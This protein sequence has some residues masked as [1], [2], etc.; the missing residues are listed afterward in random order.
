M[1]EP[2]GTST[3]ARLA[4]APLPAE[5]QAPR[6]SSFNRV[7]RRLRGGNSFGSKVFQTAGTNLLLGFLGMATSVLTARLLGTAGRGELAAIQLW[8]VMIS[9]LAM[10]GMPEALVYFCARKQARAGS[11]LATGMVLGLLA[12]V[13][14]AVGAW[15]AMPLLLKAQAPHVIEASR[16]YL[17]MIP[18]S[19]LNLTTQPFLSRTNIALW[20]LIRLAPALGWL[21]VLTIGAVI[22][23]ASP[24]GLAAA[25]LVV[26]ALIS[27]PKLILAKRKLAG[28]FAPSVGR[29]GKL[30]R[31]GI[32]SMLSIAPRVLSWRVDQ[33]MIAAIMPAPV[34]GLYSVA[35][36]WSNSTHILMHAL[37]TAFFPRLAREYLPAE[38][39]RIF[40]RGTRTSLLF[41]GSVAVAVGIATPLAIP[42]LFGPEFAGA[43]PVALLLLV[44]AAIAGFVIVLEEGLRGLGN[45]QAVMYAETAGLLATVAL[46]ALLLQPL[47]M[48]GAALAAVGG[49]LAIAGV[50]VG[51]AVRTMKQSVWQICVPRRDDVR[52]IRNS[53]HELYKNLR[54]D[55]G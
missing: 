23:R 25:Y 47:G 48:L 35:V 26:L 29:A 11:Y 45:P 5:V 6:P 32:P 53:A 3:D 46:L 42:L 19:A 8:P 50:L 14:F 9:S 21:T 12:S 39:T 40:L 1:T 38:R 17:L 15:F 31:Y 34:L 49:T 22:G 55:A 36:G 13:P 20:N 16:W 7:I 10:L 27:V 51:Y 30:L 52:F 18:L 54:S 2:A 33:L 28:R 43:V 41:S 4:A 44:A 37:G 24:A